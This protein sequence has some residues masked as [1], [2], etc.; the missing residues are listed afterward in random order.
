MIIWNQIQS[1][2]KP[3]PMATTL[4]R[5]SHPEV[6]LVKDVQKICSKFTGERPCRSV[7][8]IKLQSFIEIAIRN[9]CSPVNLLHIFRTAFPKNTSGWLLLTGV[10]RTLSNIYNGTFSENVKRLKTLTYISFLKCKQIYFSITLFSF[11]LKIDLVDIINKLWWL[12]NNT[13]KTKTL[14]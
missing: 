12:K 7:I 11:N 8:S 10:L 9:G 13:K 4:A 1:L 14:L 2:Q 6:L 3:N 5:S